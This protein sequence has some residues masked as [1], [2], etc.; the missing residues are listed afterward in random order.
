VPEISP[1]T[2]EPAAIWVAAPSAGAEDLGLGFVRGAVAG[3]GA[4]AAGCWGSLSRRK[5]DIVTS[6]TNSSLGQ[7]STEVEKKSPQDFCLLSSAAHRVSIQ[8]KING[9]MSGTILLKAD[10]PQAPE[11]GFAVAK[12]APSLPTLAG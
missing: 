12:P 2:L 5:I 4:G 3:D 9:W 7:L 1:T 11:R 6:S 10:L 8:S